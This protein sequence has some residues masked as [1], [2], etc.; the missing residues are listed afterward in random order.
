[1]PIWLWILGGCGGFGCLLWLMYRIRW[2]Q[3]LVELIGS[4]FEAVGDLDF[5]FDDD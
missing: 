4:V 3:I 2:L 5:D 1:M